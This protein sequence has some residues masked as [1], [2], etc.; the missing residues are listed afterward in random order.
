MMVDLAGK[1][2]WEQ[3]WAQEAFPPDIEPHSASLWAHRDRLVHRAIARLIAGRPRGLH[4][5]ELGCARSA[6]MPY[7]AREFG[8][9]VAGLDYSPLGA[10]QTAVRLRQSGIDGQVRCADLFDPPSDWIGSFD[11]VSWFGVAEHFQDT[12]AAIRAAASLLKPG[13]LMITQVPNMAGINGTLQRWFNK[14]VYDIHVPLDAPTLA[15]HHARA[16]LTVLSSEYVVPMDFGVVDIEE[17]PEGFARRVKDKILY[18][19]RL[20]GACV[21]WLDRRIGPFRPGRLTGASVIVGAQKPL[22]S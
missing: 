6:W 12:T 11:V 5:V 3:M 13:G 17:L 21:W 9:Q 14:P 16:G 19:L 10:E 2:H 1:A 22:T 8:C 7:F 15:A 18:A 20:F 4:V